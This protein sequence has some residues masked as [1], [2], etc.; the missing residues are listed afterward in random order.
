MNTAESPDEWLQKLTDRELLEELTA[1]DLRLER[2]QRE[3]RRRMSQRAAQEHRQ[4]QHEEIS[5]MVEQLDQTTMHWQKVSDFSRDKSVEAPETCG[6]GSTVWK[7]QCARSCWSGSMSGC[8][9]TRNSPWTSM[10]LSSPA[11]MV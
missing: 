9:T 7:K 1:T 6:N 4:A 10:I 3:V 8:S 5:R 11:S 2:L